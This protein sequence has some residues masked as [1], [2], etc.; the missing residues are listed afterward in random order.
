MIDE[1]DSWVRL[2]LIQ[3]RVSFLFCEYVSMNYTKINSE[4]FF[5]VCVL[6]NQLSRQITNNNDKVGAGNN[7]FFKYNT[8]TFFFKIIFVF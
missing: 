4:V 3:F 6:F 8:H 1:T 2:P 7:Q 5:L